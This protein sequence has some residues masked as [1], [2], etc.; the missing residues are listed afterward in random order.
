[1]GAGQGRAGQDM[2]LSAV[3]Y[4]YY[5]WWEGACCTV[6]GMRYWGIEWYRG[7]GLG[8]GGWIDGLDGRS[9]GRFTGWRLFLYCIVLCYVV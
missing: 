8:L 3:S 2:V 6:G 9:V 1:M 7:A 5:R 4:A